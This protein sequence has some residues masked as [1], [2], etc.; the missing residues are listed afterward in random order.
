MTDMKTL[1]EKTK[2]LSDEYKMYLDDITNEIRSVENFLKDECVH[3]ELTISFG[4]DQTL[5]WKNLY[6]RWLFV[7]SFD[8]EEKPANDTSIE[9]REEIY[10]ALPVFVELYNAELE[11]RVK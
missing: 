1:L 5:S 7:Y 11:K 9:I 2:S 8:G 10:R 6:D 4:R 3:L